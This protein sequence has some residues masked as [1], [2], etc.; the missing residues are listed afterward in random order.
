[1]VR[2]SLFAWLV[3]LVLVV[4]GCGG[5]GGGAGGGEAPGG[6]TVL[7]YAL[8]NVDQA[9]VMEQLAVEFEKTHPNVHVQVQVTP[10]NEYFTKLQTAIS[11]GAGAD[12]FWLKIG[13]ASCRE[14]V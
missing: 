13:R 2:K 3:V 10:F 14:R 11:G 5:G 12:V 4:T 9:P 1:M 8:W 7:A 6:K